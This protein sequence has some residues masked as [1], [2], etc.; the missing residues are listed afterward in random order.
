MTLNDR[1]WLGEIFNDTKHRAVSL[2]QLSFFQLDTV[3]GDQ[4]TAMSRRRHGFRSHHDRQQQQPLSPRSYIN[5][6][7]SPT[8]PAVF[9]SLVHRQS[10]RT[11]SNT[12][13]AN[14][15]D[16]TN[17]FVDRLRAILTA[18]EWCAFRPVRLN[19]HQSST[20]SRDAP[21]P[22]AVRRKSHDISVT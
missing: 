14:W 10:D 4:G 5:Y 7:L 8:C 12:E 3:D 21:A 20:E 22:D 6:R 9:L 1:E 19:L 11:W 17:T 15:T 18:A 16:R 13:Q 2:R